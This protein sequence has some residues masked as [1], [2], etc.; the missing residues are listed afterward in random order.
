MDFHMWDMNDDVLIPVLEIMDQENDGDGQRDPH[1]DVNELC[2]AP[3]APVF[4]RE[5]HFSHFPIEF[6]AWS[7]R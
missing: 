7:A 6:S 5:F 4:A 2:F 3:L 1:Q